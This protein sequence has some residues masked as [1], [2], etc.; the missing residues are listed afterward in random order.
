MGTR[1][2]TLQA[3][4]QEEKDLLLVGENIVFGL[5]HL[6]ICGPPPVPAIILS[7]KVPSGEAVTQGVKLLAL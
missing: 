4:R 3:E 7:S 5:G 6:W 1:R 2:L